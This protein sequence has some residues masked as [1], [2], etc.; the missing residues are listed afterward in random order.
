[1]PIHNLWPV[2]VLIEDLDSSETFN[3]T[4]FGEILQLSLENEDDNRPPTVD[5]PLNRIGDIGE[6]LK[7]LLASGV[8]KYIEEEDID[9]TSFSIG[10]NWA[11]ISSPQKRTRLP[12]HN[13]DDLGCH[14]LGVY[15]V[16]NVGE[17]D[18][19]ELE[20]HDPKWINPS[21]FNPK[22]PYNNFS[23]TPKAG[24]LVLMPSYLWHSVSDFYGNSFRVSIN[25][26]V[27]LK[28]EENKS[29]V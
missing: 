24:R 14:L 10:N 9:C 11:N 18:G 4:I 2:P 25:F 20:I 27:D 19:G 7:N 1:M 13:D 16:T 8:I 26:L 5:N 22:K 21:R 23:I 17:D 15:Y 12:L 29:L 28:F 6:E 3:N